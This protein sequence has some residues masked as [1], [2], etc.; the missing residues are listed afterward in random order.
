MSGRRLPALLAI[1][2]A[3]A[4]AGCGSTKIYLVNATKTTT[5]TPAR[6]TPLLSYRVPSGAMQPTLMIGAL[7]HARARGTSGTPSPS[8]GQIVIF[9]PP[10]DAESEV[11]GAVHVPTAACDSSEPEDTSQA[12]IKRIVAGPGHVI[13][14]INGQVIRND[15]REAASYILPCTPAEASLCNFPTKIKIPAGM[16]FMLGDNRGASDD[17]RFFGPIPTRSIIA[18]VTSD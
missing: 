9:H 16:W 17:S 15:Q 8:V 6:A 3:A 2:A 5:V 13:Q 11:C 10:R 14:I 7:V 4:V 18:L 12:F 1:G